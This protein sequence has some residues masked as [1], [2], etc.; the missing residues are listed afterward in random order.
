MP[1]TINDSINFIL[2][3]NEIKTQ[4]QKTIDNPAIIGMD[5]LRVRNPNVKFDCLLRG[6]V[7]EYAILKWFNDNGINITVTNFTND[8]DNVDVDFYYQ[9]KNIEL[10]TSLVPDRDRTVAKAIEIEDIKL[11]KRQET[12]IED[13]RGDI[14]LQIYFDKMR[15]VKDTWLQAQIIDL[16]SRDLDYLYNA[17]NA[18]DY[19][20]D[21]FFVAWIDKP[22]LIQQI[23]LLPNNI[24]ARTWSFPQSMRRFWN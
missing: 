14:H 24:L 16:T 1:V 15:R 20:N 19:C 8:G 10:K 22:T 9:E 6:Y 17:F 23:N 13:L 3:E 11:I 12:R 18:S 21:T 7:G 2:T 5:N 4:I